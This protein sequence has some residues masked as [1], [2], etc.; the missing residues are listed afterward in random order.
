[1]ESIR[2]YGF[3][4]ITLMLVSLLKQYQ[5]AYGLIAVLAALTLAM[6][7][8]LGW[9]LPFFQWVQSISS[10]ADMQG[11]GSVMKAA[12]VALLTRCV[13]ELCRDAG[14][15]ALAVAVDFAGRCLILAAA[16][17]VMQRV[18]DVLMRLLQ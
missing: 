17:P 12:G 15:N 13:Q 10:L 18:L 6:G 2:L 11:L 4:L 7:A 5:P 14:Q 16:M 1:M 3:F 9:A 8:A